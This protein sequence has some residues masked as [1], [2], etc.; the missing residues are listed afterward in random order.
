MHPTRSHLSFVKQNHRRKSFPANRPLLS[1]CFSSFASLSLSSSIL[2]G[3][4]L[5]QNHRRKSFPANLMSVW[6]WFTGE[7]WFIFADSLCRLLHFRRPSAWYTVPGTSYFVIAVPFKT[8][9][10]L[11]PTEGPYSE[12]VCV[13]V[14]CLRIQKRI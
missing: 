13:H 12:C 3:L 8:N 7:L 10:V 5:K 9:A 6:A 2:C 14:C 11:V 1:V 4:F